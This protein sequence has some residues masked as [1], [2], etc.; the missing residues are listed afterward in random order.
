M[1]PATPSPVLRTTRLLDQVRERIRYKHDSLRTEEAYVQWVRKVVKWHG[2]RHPRDMGWEE[3]EG[4]LAMLANERRV[5]ASTHNQALSALLGDST[6]FN[7]GPQPR[8]HLF[9]AVLPDAAVV[10]AANALGQSL[11]ARHGL[12]AQVRAERLHVTLMSLGWAHALS[13]EQ[14]AWARG[15]AA[16]VSVAP[17]TLRL[18]RALSFDRPAR[19]KRPWVL[20]GPG[21]A[22][23]GFHALHVA[24]HA[25][26]WPA[27]PVPAVMPHM[28]LCYSHQAVPA[29]AVAPLEWTVRRFALLHNLRG[30]SGPYEVLGEWPLDAAGTGQ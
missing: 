6:Q 28:T 29:Q 25:A 10:Q 26:L 17:F 11:I 30:S 27:R 20:C 12:Q 24:L 16:R 5:A 23:A 19:A 13:A 15:A 9:F 8:H 3:V 1:K 14:L 7:A 21:D 18:D 4:F 22:H 2:L